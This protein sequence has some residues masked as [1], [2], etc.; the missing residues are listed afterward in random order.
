MGLSEKDW[1]CFG[2][3]LE[4][5]G[6]I[7]AISGDAVACTGLDRLA[8]GADVLIQC[9][10]LAEEEITNPALK[11]LAEHVIAT[12]DQVGKIATLN[13]VK[14]LVLTHITPKSERM[15]NSLIEDVRRDYKGEI[16]LGEDL[17]IINL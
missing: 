3:R 9:C 14:K 4:A 6:K 17:M 10:Y 5:E 11:Q 16:C 8:F 15:M 7:I 1:P 2:Y 13:K 12:S